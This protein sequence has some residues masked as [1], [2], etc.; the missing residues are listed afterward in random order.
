MTSIYEAV[1]IRSVIQCHKR[2]RGYLRIWYLYALST[3]QF[4]Q[5]NMK[6]LHWRYW[7]SLKIGLLFFAKYVVQ[8]ELFE[9]V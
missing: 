6:N 3:I 5:V 1:T 8:L 7:E 2:K 9:K 4:L